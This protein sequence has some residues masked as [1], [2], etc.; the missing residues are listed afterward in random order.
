VSEPSNTDTYT[1]GHHASVVGQHARRTAEQDAAFLLP[2][3]R[4]GMDLLD[5][6]CGPG[7]IT[8]GL[9]RAVAPGEVIGV[10]AAPEV[11]EV[12]RG[13]AR[14]QGVENVHFEEGSVYALRFAEATFDAV[15]A[16][17]VL[18]H[19]GDPVAALIEM[20]R[21]LKPAGMTA[22]RD[23]DYGTMVAWP[24]RP[25]I[26]RFLEVYHAVARRNGADADA[27]RRIPAWLNEAGYVDLEI[28]AEV[29]LFV[30]PDD[31]AN[32]GESWA[33]R[34]LESSL[35]TQA[36]EYGIA[37]RGDLEVIAQGW[38]AW[39]RAPHATFM[40]TQVQGIGHA[41]A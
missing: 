9:A 29:R 37:S 24:A 2:R 3:L 32:W 21:V 41:P 20:R 15:Y 26:T 8:L 22:V 25:E 36:V 38:R 6:G 31:V 1:H 5:V 17:Q 18:Q 14:Q 40:Y 34:V 33:D 13:L 16:H 19:L 12:A 30:E 39:A 7:S 27:G 35:A 11:L 28:S 23:A 4:P 10:D